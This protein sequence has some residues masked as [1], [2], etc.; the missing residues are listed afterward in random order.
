VNPSLEFLFTSSVSGEGLEDWYD[1]LRAQ[2]GADV[3]S[4]VEPEAIPVGP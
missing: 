1:F 2:L 4:P 3:A